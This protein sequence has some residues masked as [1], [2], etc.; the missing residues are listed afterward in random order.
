[1]VFAPG[2]S[3]FECL[4]DGC[5]EPAISKGL[6][7]SHYNRQYYSGDP[8]RRRRS[9]LCLFCGRPFLLERS[10][11]KFC[12]ARCR[13]RFERKRRKSP[14]P[15]DASP[16]PV[17]SS[18]PI[19]EKP[20][21]RMAYVSFTEADV[22]DSCNGLCH[23]C[24]LPAS[25]DYESPDLGTPAWIVPLADGGEPSLRNKTIFHYRCLG[26]HVS[27]TVERDARHGRKAGGHGRKRKE[28]GEA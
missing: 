4:I 12:S 7:R 24:G 2:V 25:R 21:R 18:I 15:L 6:C 19:P 8:V 13:K 26:R 1:M 22:W 16:L 14:L 11:R 5:D 27:R 9:R 17:V 23:E 28:G 20:K 3:T 10:S